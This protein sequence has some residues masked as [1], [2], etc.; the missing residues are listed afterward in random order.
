MCFAH[1][2]PVPAAAQPRARGSSWT[3]SGWGPILDV[4]I[5]VVVVTLAFGAGLLSR[6]LTDLWGDLG[7]MLS[8]VLLLLVA[9]WG[10]WQLTLAWQWLESVPVALVY[11]SAIAAATTLFVPFRAELD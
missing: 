4:A 8:L 11:G 6:W 5:L 7:Q 1:S 3:A 10:A 2:S 9:L